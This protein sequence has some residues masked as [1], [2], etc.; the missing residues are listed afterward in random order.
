M[1]SDMDKC[2]K[3]AASFGA[4]AALQGKVR[5]QL[6]VRKTGQVY[7]AYIHSTIGLDNKV[8]NSCFVNAALLWLYQPVAVDNTAPFPLSVVSS[9]AETGGATNAAAIQSGSVAPTIFMPSAQ[10]VVEPADLDEKLAQGT[11]EIRDDCSPAEQGQALLAVHK[12]PEAIAQLRL[13][14]ASNPVDTIA[15]RGLS[16]ALV[17][18]RGDLAEARSAA[19]KLETAAPGSV[20]GPEAM[21][22]VCAAQK[23]DLCV[24]EQW[25]KKGQPDLGPRSRI[26]ADLQPLAQA[27]ADRLA[28]AARA[29]AAGQ[30]PATPAA[31]P[32]AASA[33]PAPA[34][35]AAADP[36]AT[37]QGDEKQALCVVKRCLEEGSVVYAK[38]LSQQNGVDYVAGEWR[39]KSVAP[40]KLL[41]TRPIG[42]KAGDAARHDAIWLVKLGDQF[43]IAPSTGEARQITLSHNACARK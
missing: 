5:L 12:Y 26:I 40:G 9:G 6:L 28:A 30:A 13:A 10:P 34:A 22:R 29:R 14:L 33:A 43:S 31:A 42:P 8:L 27:A 16:Q 18:S 21:L 24:L 35:A 37:E 15:L 41:V 1:Q 20:V 23:D 17:E 39:T 4:D 19:E 11:L 7:A 36:C 3:R 38:E 25:K 2:A 32:A